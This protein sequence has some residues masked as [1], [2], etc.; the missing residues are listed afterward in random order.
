MRAVR[1]IG[2]QPHCCRAGWL[3]CLAAQVMPAIKR[4]QSSA[5]ERNF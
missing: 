4:T 2:V 5:L 1:P 3:D